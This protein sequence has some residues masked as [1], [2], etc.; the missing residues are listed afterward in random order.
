MILLHNLVNK[1]SGQKQEQPGQQ[2]K[3]ICRKKILI[4][5]T[6]KGHHKSVIPGLRQMT[7][8]RRKMD[9]MAT[10]RLQKNLYIPSVYRIPYQKQ[11][12]GYD[13]TDKAG[14]PFQPAAQQ[15]AQ[16]HC[17][18]QK[19]QYAKHDPVVRHKQNGH[20]SHKQPC[21]R[22]RNP[23][24][25]RMRTESQRKTGQ[26]NKAP[27]DALLPQ[28]ARLPLVPRHIRVE[29]IYQIPAGVISDH[30]DQSQPP[31]TVNFVVPHYL[32]TSQQ[33]ICAM[34]FHEL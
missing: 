26:Q 21:Q 29:Q 6:E 4:H 10:V 15:S 8:N 19:C 28:K 5:K 31:Q 12:K 22:Y 25:H 1:K 2:R 11:K 9:Q 7:G 20:K 24:A 32:M 16:D 27:A 17:A 14:N 33:I 13:H 34:S 30:T 23:S 18:S 3:I